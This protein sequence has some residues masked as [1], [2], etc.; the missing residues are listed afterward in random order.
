MRSRIAEAKFLSYAAVQTLW[1]GT[2]P[3][4]VSLL[5][6]PP[7]TLVTTLS[8]AAVFGMYRA[9]ARYRSELQAMSVAMVSAS[10]QVTE[11]QPLTSTGL[12]TAQRIAY[13]DVKRFQF[14]AID[15]EVEFSQ[16]SQR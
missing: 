7:W 16:V 10:F 12:L 8:L 6:F 2:V 9:T 15:P 3:C 5:L 4:I 11:A 1:V 14:C 13:E